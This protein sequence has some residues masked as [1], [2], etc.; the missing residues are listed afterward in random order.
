MRSATT[1]R[2]VY[3]YSFVLTNLD[4]STPEKTAEVEHWYR[5]RTD[6]EALNKDAKI[7]AALRHL[8]SGDPVVNTVWT[9]SAL[10]AAAMSAWLQELPGS[11]GATAGDGAPS[12]GSAANSSTSPPASCPTPAASNCYYRRVPTSCPTRSTAS[13][14]SHGQADQ[15]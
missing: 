14:L 10:L 6:I 12:P 7:G 11:T 1:P 8:P 5:H 2:N 13:G 15:Q 3:G 4:V 9:W